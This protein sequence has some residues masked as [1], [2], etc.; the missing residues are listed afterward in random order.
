M[1]Q[2]T[3][4]FLKVAVILISIPVLALCFIGFPLMLKDAA[5]NNNEFVNYVY[6]IVALI[7]VTMIPFFIALYQAFKLLIYIDRN[8]AF[9][10]LSVVAL[11]N[12]KNCAVVISICY[13][14]GLPLFFLFGDKDDAPGVVV[15]GLVFIFAP[16]VIATFAAV[17]QRL[18]KEAIAIKSENDLTI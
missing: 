13:V 16:A 7:Y 5:E 9:S 6:S 18:L 12:I 10:D 15:I 14:L 17:L 11:K 4:L 1:K 3:T 2:G 8:Q